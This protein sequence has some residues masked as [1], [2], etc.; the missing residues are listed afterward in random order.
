M[1]VVSEAKV[2]LGE[3]TVQK[4][5]NAMRF[6]SAIFCTLFGLAVPAVSQSTFDDQ[7]ARPSPAPPAGN[8]L[9]NNEPIA[10]SPASHGPDSSADAADQEK[11]PVP[12]VT[13][14]KAAN[15]LLNDAYKDDIAAAVTADQKKGMAQK[16]LAAANDERGANRYALFTTARDFAVEAGDLEVC[17]DALDGI[18]A[19]FDVDSPKLRSE[20]YSKIARNVRLSAEETKLCKDISSTVQGAV[21]A[22]QFDIAAAMADLGLRIARNAD[23]STLVQQAAADVQ[24]VH[25]EEA[26]YTNVKKALFA[27]SAN[28]SDAEANL[29]VGKYRCF[30]KGDWK[31]GLPLL[32]LGSDATIKALAGREAAGVASVDDEVRLGDGWWDAANAL[33]GISRTNVQAHVAQWYDAAVLDLD[34]GLIRTKIE[35]RLAEIKINRS[36]VG[37]S[38]AQMPAETQ[39]AN[40]SQAMKA[41]LAAAKSAFLRHDYTEAVAGLAGLLAANVGN[42]N[43]NGARDLA[44]K[45]ATAW[46]TDLNRQGQSVEAAKTLLR[47]ATILDPDARSANLRQQARAIV[48][49]DYEKAV[50]E[51]NLTRAIQIAGDSAV[52]FPDDPRLADDTTIQSLMLDSLAPPLLEK[53]EVAYLRL[54]KLES[55]RVDPK[56]FDQSK[57]DPGAIALAYVRDLQGRGWAAQAAAVGREALASEKCSAE[58]KTK[59]ENAL[60]FALIASAERAP[61]IW[62]FGDGAAGS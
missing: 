8:V 17:D 35:K 60:S 51:K 11:P 9:S 62:Q 52:V 1:S 26:N 25:E 31:A 15:A 19:S 40:L 56:R 16:L 61:C 2:N 38:A 36:L 28:P 5:G 47:C 58:S 32:A 33:S 45:V 49:G 34:K 42:T 54:R 43:V 4:R 14:L 24:A 20:A 44:V 48:V 50:T 10:A 6:I 41:E 7:P 30:I 29:T 22:D 12:D 37:I 13:A 27:L 59:L 3:V 18:E 21:A 23:A 57:V 53:P 55:M 39:A 46:S